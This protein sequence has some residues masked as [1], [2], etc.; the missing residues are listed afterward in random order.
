MEA[1]REKGVGVGVGDVRVGR[2][3]ARGAL[4]SVVLSVLL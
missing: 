2:Q 3:S 4:N 1:V